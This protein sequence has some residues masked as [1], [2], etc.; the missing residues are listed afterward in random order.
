MKNINNKEFIRGIIGLVVYFI[1]NKIDTLPFALFGVDVNSIPNWVKIIYLIIYEI[2]TMSIM[3]LIF[4]KKLERDLKDIL[5]NHRKL[6]G[7]CFKYYL[8]GLAIMLIS[9]IFI[10]YVFKNNLANNETTVRNLF[11]MMPIYIYISSVFFA[12][13]IEELTF[14]QSMENIFGRNYI[15]VILS[16]LLFGTLH[17]ISSASGIGDLVYIIPY[18]ALGISFAYMLYKTDNIFVSMG[19]HMMHNGLL[20]AMQFLILFF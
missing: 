14:R 17:V 3:I 7:D 4:Y 1:L 12:P 5:K 16:G 19:F 20:L 2:M 9:N 13:L 18:S 8:I 15:F 10:I 11:K 6:Y